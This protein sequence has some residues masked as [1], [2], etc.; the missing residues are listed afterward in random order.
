MNFALV[1]QSLLFRLLDAI[2]RTDL[3]KEIL[4]ERQRI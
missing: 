1:L 4:S 3:L 2:V